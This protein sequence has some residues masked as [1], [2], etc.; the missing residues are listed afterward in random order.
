MI[1]KNKDYI[2]WVEESS[3]CNLRPFELK[4]SLHVKIKKEFFN[5]PIELLKNYFCMKINAIL[6]KYP[7][8]ICLLNA[9]QNHSSTTITKFG[10]QKG[11]VFKFKVYRIFLLIIPYR[12]F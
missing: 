8:I 6:H 11:H 12:K 7:A 2:S 4:N 3:K 10:N 1:Y 5:Q 9:L